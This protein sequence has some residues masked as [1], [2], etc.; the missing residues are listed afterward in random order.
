LFIPLFISLLFIGLKHQEE[1]LEP[2]A[3]NI[4]GVNVEENK[5]KESIY[6]MEIKC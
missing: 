4:K 2:W 6:V 5:E 1:K 3:N